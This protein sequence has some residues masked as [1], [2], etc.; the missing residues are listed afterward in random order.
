MLL[1]PFAK[2]IVRGP[3]V[4]STIRPDAEMSIGSKRFFVE[5]DT[6][7]ETHRQVRLKWS[8][9]YRKIRFGQHADFLLV[10]TLKKSRIPELARNA[11]QVSS[12]ALFTC[13]DDVLADPH[14]KVWSD[15]NGKLARIPK[16]KG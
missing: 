6:G 4:H 12:L 8:Q 3:T 14:G 13:L 10:V 9:N 2:K 1:Y 7:E 5:L 16:P 15:F 11:K